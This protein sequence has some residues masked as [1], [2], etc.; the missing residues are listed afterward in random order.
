MDISSYELDDLL[1]AAIKS[2]VESEAVYLQLANKV[3]NGFLSEKL[4]FIASEE[5]KHGIYLESVFKMKIQREPILPETSPVPL[6]ELQ[7]QSSTVPP[8]EIVFQAMKAE[9]TASKFYKDLSKRFEDREIQ[10]MLIYLSEMEIGHY[11]LLELEKDKLDR[12][13]EY[14]IEWEMM[15]I[16]P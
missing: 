15:H 14:E 7:L 9:E 8:S 13:E 1:L 12:E 16:G 3:N 2:E 5:K 4:R 10:D 11:R 6:P